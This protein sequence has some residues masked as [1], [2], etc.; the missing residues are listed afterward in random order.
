VTGVENRNGRFTCRI[1]ER[2][3]S[4]GILGAGILALDLRHLD[5]ERDGKCVCIFTLHLCFVL[6]C[7]KC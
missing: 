7:E 5:F 1:L 4:D 6:D 3:Q 2:R